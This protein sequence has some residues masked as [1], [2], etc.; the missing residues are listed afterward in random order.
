M[1]ESA[2]VKVLIAASERYKSS[3][4]TMR[5]V[6]ISSSSGSSL[7]TV[8]RLI[9]IGRI[10]AAMPISSNIFIILLPITL[11]IKIS[12]LP[13]MSDENDTASSGAPVPK[14]M[15]VRP[16]KSLLTLKFDATDDAPSMSQSAPLIKITKPTISKT[17][18]RS[19]SIVFMI[20]AQIERL[21][22]KKTAF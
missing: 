6:E 19:I 3:I 20:I 11:P 22:N 9:L 12:V 17:I 21:A 5:A 14:A 1:I 2:R 8:S 15:I 7:D 10:M 18:C 16:I 4:N 13:L